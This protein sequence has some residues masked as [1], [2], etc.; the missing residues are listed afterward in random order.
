MVHRPPR[1]APR[2]RAMNPDIEPGQLAGIAQLLVDR[3][4]EVTGPMHAELIAGGRSNWTY[5][6]HDSTS[7]WVLRRPPSGGFTP[8]AHDMKREHRITDAL[9]RAGVAVARPVLH[10]EST[11]LL[12]VPFTVAQFV[13]GLSIRSQEDLQG[14]DDATVIDITASLMAS[15]AAIHQVDYRKAGLDSW[16]RADRYAER[17]LKR[18]SGQWER[19]KVTDYPAAAKMRERLAAALPSQPTT[20]VVHGDFRIDNV[21]LD[22]VDPT[23]VLAVVDWELSTL[24]DPVADVALSCVYRHP[25]FDNVI[26]LQSAWTSHRLPALEDLAAMYE[27]SSA[28]S[29]DNWEFWLAMG[30]YKLAVIAQGIDHRYR[31]G[32]TA[33]G[34]YEGVAGSVPELLNAALEVRLGS[35]AELR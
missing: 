26:G 17:Q 12:G 32:A 25:A 1:R 33:T 4:V 34:E 5:R 7:A 6:L 23:R 15:L 10:H 8:S 28:R 13:E 11:E 9:A 18:W 29:L 35:R 3:G 31:A 30:Y 14:F 2:D 16:A 24:G 27:S 22:I 21:L 20:G 19:V